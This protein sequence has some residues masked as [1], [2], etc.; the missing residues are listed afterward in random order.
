MV[1]IATTGAGPR[2]ALAS[3]EQFASP[4]VDVIQSQLSNFAR[5]KSKSSQQK[6]NGKIPFDDFPPVARP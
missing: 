2:G 4:P 3:N 5:T 1:G 6:E